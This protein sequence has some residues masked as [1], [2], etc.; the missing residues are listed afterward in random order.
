MPDE[1]DASRVR[2]ILDAAVNA[3]LKRHTLTPGGDAA[4]FLA[5]Y[6]EACRKAI[7]SET[8]FDHLN[9][10]VMRALTEGAK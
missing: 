8:L 4:G 6:C 9:R 2:G 3:E 10:A 1:L 5:F 7:T